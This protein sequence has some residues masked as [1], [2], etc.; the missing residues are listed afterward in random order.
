MAY[1]LAVLGGLLAAGVFGIEGTIFGL[2]LG[3]LLGTMFQQK[4][5]LQQLESKISEL[6]ESYAR[7]SQ[8]LS[9]V[10]QSD[11]AMAKA[12]NKT[13]RT[14]RDISI[15]TPA[16]PP[17]SSS[18]AKTDDTDSNDKLDFQPIHQAADASFNEDSDKVTNARS[19][20]E[21]VSDQWSATSG[22]K[23]V[24]ALDGMISK[25]A[26]RVKDYF[27]SGNLIVR[28]G[29]IVLFFGVGFLLKFAAENS[30]L[31]IEFRLAG[32]AVGG[33]IML[34]LGW[35]LR[36]QQQTYALAL[37]G[38]AVGVLY[39]TVFAALRLYTVLPAT[40]ALVLMLLFV[41]FSAAL[42]L[43]QNA[44]SLAVLATAGGF[45]APILTSTGEGSHVALFSY[46]LLLNG[47]VLAIAW[48]RAWRVLNLVGFG[49]TFVIGSLWGFQYYQPSFF[50]ST[51][52]F[53]VAF[54][55]LYTAIAVLFALRQPPN[56]KG[57]VDGTLVFGVPLAAAGLQ[58]M[59][60]KDYEYGL[61][62]SSITL[63]AFYILL[64]IILFRRGGVPLRLLS[65]S[66]L[67]TGVVFATLAV[68]FALEGR[69]S[70]AFWALEGAAMVWVGLRQ[71]RLVPRLFGSALQLLGALLYIEDMHRINWDMPLLNSLFL[72]TTIIAFSGLFSGFY[73]NRHRDKVHS[74]E[75]RLPVLLLIWGILW[76][77]FG[78]VREIDDFASSSTEW[79]W[80]LA[81]LAVTGVV[82]QILKTRLSWTHLQWLGLA[83]LPALTLAA[84]GV[85]VDESHPFVGWLA[86]GWFMALTAQYWI[87]HHYDNPEALWFR[88]SHGLSY[89]LLTFLIT[90]ETIWQIEQ[91]IEGASTWEAIP[92]GLV[93]AL[94]ILCLFTLGKRLD[95]P[96]VRYNELY[97]FLVVAPIAVYLLIWTMLANAVYPGSPW[98]LQFI[99]VVNPLDLTLL[100][101]IL[102][103]FKWWQHSKEQLNARGLSRQLYLAIL[104]GA[105]FLLLN[106]IVARTVHH[107]SGIA[108]NSHALFNSQTF[109]AS[110]A[111]LWGS[112]GLICMLG[113]TRF[114]YRT[115]WLVGAAMMVLVVAKLFLV[116]L[117]NSGTV[118]RIVSFIGVG[119]LLL[120]VGYFSPA[121]PRDQNPRQEKA[122]NRAEEAEV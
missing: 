1:I 122:D 67:S 113:G 20:T 97:S 104:G 12:D 34:L 31:P 86:L 68:P 119:L 8:A 93:P 109:Q 47:G 15:A 69:L 44:R 4:R 70:A 81:V 80:L 107:W 77:L 92:F 10:Q 32:V 60:I 56:L 30:M 2:V 54:F 85:M 5:R 79:A 7:L 72:G 105:L 39:L 94:M 78:V 74:L 22:H 17:S 87:L 91:L 89:W 18:A 114:K 83:L 108:F 38:G 41:A 106:G 21:S 90:T 55:L 62:F 36:N 64:A 96:V 58:A 95:W 42:A 112:I 40:L 76:W 25:L 65:E 59:L 52:P 71:N 49:F 57:M 75:R 26:V 24:S 46:Y 48:F 121:P 6:G 103:L 35:R 61:A 102:V 37:Q 118:A 98:P 53:L 73:I 99:P 28:V 82:A 45:M 50:A 13:Q 11:I 23:T 19:E 101:S 115:L 3:F 14:T 120:V 84:L 116:D 66:F 88:L 27:T 16:D 43:L 111:V 51:E 9:T 29:V 33:I 63:G 100:F 110:I 117:S